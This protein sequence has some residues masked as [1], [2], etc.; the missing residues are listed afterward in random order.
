MKNNKT[1][2]SWHLIFLF[3]IVIF[4]IF[5]KFYQNHFS[6][7]VVILNGQKLNV[8]IAETIYQQHK[9]LGG[10]GSLKPYDGMIFPYGIPTKPTMV[11]RDMEFP[12]DIVWLYDGE[13]V[14]IAPNLPIEPNTPEG[15]LTMYYPRKQANLVLE[16]PAGWSNRNKLKIGDKLTLVED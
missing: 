4:S 16:L 9:G 12:I 14:D 6:D 1:I 5:L 2:K 11:M 10:R 15:Y 7:T 8:L 13:V 3:A